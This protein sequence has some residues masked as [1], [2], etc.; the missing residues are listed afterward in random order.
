MKREDIDNKIDGYINLFDHCIGGQELPIQWT[1][2]PIATYIEDICKAPGNIELCQ[3]DETWKNIFHQ[4]ILS[5]LY[6]MLPLFEH[7]ESEYNQEISTV[8]KFFGY[9]FEEKRNA[10]DE[11]ALHLDKAFGK[12]V[13]NIHGYILELEKKEKSE[14]EIFEAMKINWE[15]ASKQRQEWQIRKLLEK[16]KQ[17]FDYRFLNPEDEDFKLILKDKK[18]MYKYPKLQEIVKVMG[19]EK[20]SHKKMDSTITKFIPILLKHCHDKQDIEGVTLGNNLNSLLPSEIAMLDSSS[21]YLKYARK[22]LQ[23]FSSRAAQTKKEK[24]KTNEKSPRLDQG[25]MILCIDTSGSMSGK[26][27]EIAQALTRQLAAIAQKEKRSCFLIS[28]SIRTKTLDLSRPSSYSKIESFFEDRYNGGSDGEGM[29]NN[30]IEQLQTNQYSMADALII[31]DFMFDLP[32]KKT[33]KK[34]KEEQNKGTK[35]YGLGIRA[36]TYYNNVLDKI[37]YISRHEC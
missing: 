2:D 8:K 17:I 14:D 25:P 4:E 18:I 30:I 16:A 27:L 9:S 33:L 35:F 34:I 5:M 26:P 1:N 10:W 28:F 13:F 6:F 29:L 31:S 3:E 32:P 20:E 24:S 21:F 15:K 19:R 22:Q 37:W 23:Q 36:W 7:I 11:T 12:N